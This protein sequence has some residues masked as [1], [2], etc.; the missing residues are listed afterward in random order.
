M[1]SIILM[2]LCLQQQTPKTPATKP[3]TRII[4]SLP[5][6]HSSKKRLPWKNAQAT[7]F[8]VSENGRNT[9]NNERCFSNGPEYLCAMPTN[10]NPRRQYCLHKQNI[11]KPVYVTTKRGEIIVVH[12]VDHCPHSSVIDFNAAAANKIF[13][14]KNSSTPDWWSRGKVKWFRD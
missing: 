7:V 6:R 2:A 12:V 11:C 14:N 1:I 13:L 5:S 3:A 4:K 8:T 9:A 10:L